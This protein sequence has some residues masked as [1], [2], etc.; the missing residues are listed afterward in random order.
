MPEY[1]MLTKQTIKKEQASALFDPLYIGKLKLNGRMAKSATVETLCTKEGFITDKFI[2]FYKEIAAGETPLIITG[3]ASYDAYS[4]G[5]PHQLSIDADDKVEGLRR[6]A[7]TVHQYESKIFVQ[8]YHTARQAL[9]EP[10]G[11]ADAQAPSVVYEPTLGVRPRAMSVAEIHE[12]IR[13]YTDAV[14]RCKNAG[15]DGVQIHAAHGYLIS[16]FLTPHTN[17]RK[18]QY[19]GSFENR[20]RF[21]VE[22]YRAVRQ[23]VGDDYPLILKING[24]D[25]LPFRKGLSTTELVKIAKKM[26]HEGIDAVEISAGHYESC[27]TFERGQWKGYTRAMLKHGPGQAFSRPKRLLMHVFGPLI[28]RFFNQV[29]GFSEGFNL[30]YAQQFSKVLNVPVI[31]VGGF[32]NKATMD[33]ALANQECDMVSVARGLL[34]D[35]RLYKHLKEDRPGPVCDYCN[36]CFTKP[37]SSPIGCYNEDVQAQKIKQPDINQQLAQIQETQVLTLDSNAG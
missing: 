32:V 24:A 22:L 3:A 6:L 33:Q 15:I 26:E 37:G 16:E 21:L 27:T 36:A 30:N 11:R 17:R 2:Q 29:A 19:G 23:R 4:R 13:L 28:D 8:I 31:C 7:S 20:T 18:D 10:V 1:A 35:P 25:D 9:P 14:E 12:T 34:A 5:V